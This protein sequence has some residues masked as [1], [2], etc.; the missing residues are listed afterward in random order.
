MEPSMFLIC[1]YLQVVDHDGEVDLPGVQILF[2]RVQSVRRDSDVDGRG[3]IA[4]ISPEV[5]LQHIHNIQ[6]RVLGVFLQL[7]QVSSEI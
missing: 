2:H 4:H 3:G 7:L 1:P 5:Q 6:N